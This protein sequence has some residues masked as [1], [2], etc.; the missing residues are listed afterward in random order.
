MKIIATTLL[1][2]FLGAAVSAQDLPTKSL[3]PG[4]WELG[5]F[6][7]GGTGLGK[8]DDTQFF[9]AGGRIGLVLTKEFLPGWA[10]GNFEYAVD[11]MPIYTVF[12]PNSAVYAG[13]FKPIILQ[14]NFTRGKTIAPYFQ[15]EGGILFSTHNIPP[16][17]TSYVN[18][19]PGVGF[20]VHIFTRES[21]AL[22][23]EGSVIHISSASLGTHNPGYNGSFFFTIGYSWYKTKK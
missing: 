17:D 16:G 15:A 7:G 22:Q 14:W 8:S 21:R 20:G 2:L 23:L 6:G 9:L 11:L 18:F 3:T 1:A 4:T 5:V 12:P 19:T 10:R 13:S